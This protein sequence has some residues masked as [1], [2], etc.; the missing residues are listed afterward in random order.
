MNLGAIVRKKM[1]GVKVDSSGFWELQNQRSMVS[2]TDSKFETACFRTVQL[3]VWV[4]VETRQIFLNYIYLPV[5]IAILPPL[6]DTLGPAR[7]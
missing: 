1:L 6:A 3:A 2:A 5:A 4:R 7:D